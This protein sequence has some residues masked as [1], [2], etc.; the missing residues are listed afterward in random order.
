MFIRPIES[1]TS[2]RHSSIDLEHRLTVLEMTNADHGL[3]ITGLE[4]K[5]PKWTPRD[6]VLSAAGVIIVLAA[7]AQKIS[8]HQAVSLLSG[9]K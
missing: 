4:N 7:L 1:H 8:W 6:L 5:S 9:M 3:R 2:W